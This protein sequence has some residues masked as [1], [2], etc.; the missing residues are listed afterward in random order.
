MGLR[1]AIG[2][3]P[4][5]K[6]FVCATVKLSGAPVTTKGYL[7]TESDLKA[8]VRWIKGQGDIIVA[9]EGSNGLSRPLE[10]ALREAQV[11]FYSFK[12]ADTDKF[13]KAVL[14]QNKDNRRDAESVARCAMA[15]EAQ[16]K[17]ERYRRVWFADA[18]ASA[19]HP[20]LRE[21]VSGCDRGAQPPV[22]AA[23]PGLA[24]SVPG[25]G[26]RPSGGRA[27]G[28][29]PANPGSSHPVE[30]ETGSQ[31]VEGPQRRAVA[32]SHGRRQV[33]GA[34]EA[35]RAVAH[36]RGKLSGRLT[37]D[38]PADPNRCQHVQRLKAEQTEIIRMLEALTAENMAVHALK[39]I[40]GI[41]TLTASTLAAE[42]I[43]V[44]RFPREDSLACYSGLGMK[45]HSAGDN[46]RMVLY[47]AVQ[48]PAEG[49]LHDRGAQL[50]A[51][52]P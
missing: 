49:C 46:F 31:P 24:G 41:A 34:G 20:W 28:E 52:Q 13:R 51:V 27:P 10:K 36:A 21:E 17:L 11:I 22:E 26:G 40:P 7:A 2:I 19:S 43:D 33:Q 38:G 29:S 5:S 6:G 47:A 12:P 14:G 48:P 23:S 30:P 8:F 18:Q 35:H 50:R 39:Q 1:D 44:R 9:I 37:G 25:P 16:G 45:E 3:D 42:I 32:G 15:L 4:D